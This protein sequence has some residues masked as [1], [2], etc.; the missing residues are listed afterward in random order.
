MEATTPSSGGM[1]YIDNMP[2]TIEQIF[3]AG[4]KKAASLGM[5]SR[6][7]DLNSEGRTSYIDVIPVNSE[8]LADMTTKLPESISQQLLELS[9]KE[10]AGLLC[11]GSLL[12]TTN[13]HFASGSGKPTSSYPFDNGFSSFHLG[14]HDTSLRSRTRAYPGQTQ[15]LDKPGGRTAPLLG[16]LPDRYSFL[17]L[18]GYDRCQSVKVYSTSTHVYDYTTSNSWMIANSLVVHN[19]TLD[20]RTRDAHLEAHRQTVPLE[21]KF[22]VG[23]EAIDHPGEGS[24]GNSIAC[25]CTVAPIVSRRM[26]RL[27]SS[28]L[29][30]ASN[31]RDG[32]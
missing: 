12:D 11:S 27:A 9:D 4:F 23:G 20:N 2:P 32:V 1:P 29:D 31:G 8:L 25:R 17:E 7:V 18:F 28:V 19:S 26:L 22:I 16:Q 21:A 14:S 15:T 10:F 13:W 30:T 3:N 6:V 5:V 24:P